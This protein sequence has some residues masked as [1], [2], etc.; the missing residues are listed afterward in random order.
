MAWI[1]FIQLMEL[2]YNTQPYH[3]SLY[4]LE[5]SLVFIIYLVIISQFNDHFG[6][7]GFY[8]V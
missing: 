7:S 1:I 3:V 5:S 6:S 4:I 2:D 8:K